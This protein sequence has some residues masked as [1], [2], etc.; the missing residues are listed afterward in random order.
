MTLQLGVHVENGKYPTL[1]HFLNSRYLL[2]CFN[3]ENCLSC[4]SEF[5][6]IPS[7]FVLHLIP[8]GVQSVFPHPMLLLSPNKC[9]PVKDHVQI[10]RPR[11]SPA[12][13]F[14]LLGWSNQRLLTP[15]NA[16]ECLIRP[17][18]KDCI[19]HLHSYAMRTDKGFMLAEEMLSWLQQ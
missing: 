12:S 17:L 5:V 10:Q 3:S 13:S 9:V 15:N 4:C 18:Q 16:P 1:N 19:R 14:F 6:R 2:L 8:V 11:K 7:V